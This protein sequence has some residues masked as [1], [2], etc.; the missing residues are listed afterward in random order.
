MN[1]PLFIVQ[2]RL[3]L[4]VAMLLAAALLCSAAPAPAAKP[5]KT[6]VVTCITDET[7]EDQWADLLIAHGMAGLIEQSLYD[8]G[9][10][11]P[12]ETDP[13]IARRMRTLVDASWRPADAA[14]REVH[15]A[16]ARE[17]G[18]DALV[19][20]VVGGFKK[21]R[22]RSF[23]GPLSRSRVRIRVIVRLTL[24]ERGKG[25]VE[26]EGSGSAVTRQAGAFFRVRDDR[27]VFDDTT[28][29]VAARKA[30]EDAVKQLMERIE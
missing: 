2:P 7:G 16:R 24:E 11:A 19:H 27:I 30:V 1:H 29:G 20:G 15:L 22:S 28:V 21:S 4:P 6:L 25:P 5:L 3:Y 18:A 23:A 26:A 10:Y 8:T 13:E 12:L 9:K 14:E 17:L